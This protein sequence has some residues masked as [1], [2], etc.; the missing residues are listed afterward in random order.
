[1]A[2]PSQHDPPKQPRRKVDKLIASY[3]MADIGQELEDRW[4]GRGVERRSLRWL[5]GWFNERLVARRL[6]EEGR[7]LLDGEAANIYRL[8]T[9]DEVGAGARVDAESTV[10]RAGIDPKVLRSEFVSHQ[11]IHT[12]L[13]ESRG[14]SK[15]ETDPDRPE[16]VRETVQRLRNRLVAVVESGLSGLVAAEQISLGEF[17]VLVEVQV[18]CADCGTAQPVTELLAESGCRCDSGG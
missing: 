9:A 8:L 1:M 17:D 15:K 11:A 2:E 18:F 3:G 12:Y 10:A 13:R 5:A 16:R 6:T 14:A 7:R 4:L